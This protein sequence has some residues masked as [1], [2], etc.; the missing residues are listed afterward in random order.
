MMTGSD[1]PEDK[2]TAHKKNLELLDQLIG[3]NKYLAG[4]DL[5]LADLSVLAT[6]SY[7]D[8]AKY[9]MSAYKNVE[10]WRS[11][12]K[13]EVKSYDEINV[14]TDEEIKVAFEKFAAKQAKKAK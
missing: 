9:D 6:L 1:P 5:T 4:N 8:I 2:V 10:R 7:A 3:N 14:F 13:K 11:Q 12:L